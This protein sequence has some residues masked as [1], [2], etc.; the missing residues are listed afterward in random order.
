M[1]FICILYC[2][3]FTFVIWRF[4]RAGHATI[5]SR[6]RNHVIRPQSCLLLQYYYIWCCYPGTP[7][8]HRDQKNLAFFVVPEAQIRCRVVVV[9]RPAQ[10]FSQLLSTWMFVQLSTRACR[11]LAG[12]YMIWRTRWVRL[13]ALSCWKNSRNPVPGSSVISTSRCCK[14]EQ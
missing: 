6:Q 1:S 2:W 11:Y 12:M 3:S 14:P 4:S 5:L 9:A 8:R 7:S 10:H 13:R